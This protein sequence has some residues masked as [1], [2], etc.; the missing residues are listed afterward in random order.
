M[1]EVRRTLKISAKAVFP[2]TGEQLRDSA[3]PIPVS[4]LLQTP[5]LF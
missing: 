4:I 2:Q 3:I 1:K 5:F